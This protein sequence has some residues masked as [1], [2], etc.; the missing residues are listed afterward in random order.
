MLCLIVM[1]NGCYTRFYHI[2][3]VLAVD[4]FEERALML[5]T[6]FSYLSYFEQYMEFDPFITPPEPSNP[7]ISDNTDHWDQESTTSVAF[8]FHSAVYMES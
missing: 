5:C 7:W 2:A 8:H 6:I 1:H 3:S 4:S